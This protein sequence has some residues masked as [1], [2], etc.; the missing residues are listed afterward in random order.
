[1]SDIPGDSALVQCFRAARSAGRPQD[2]AEALPY[3]RFLG[4]ETSLVDGRLQVVLPFRPMLVGNPFLPAIHGGVLG[5]LIELAAS[6]ELI[7]RHDT[8]RL[9]KVVTTTVDFARSGQPR[10]LF[11]EA[12]VTRL[13]RRIATVAVRLWQDDAQR[14][15][16]TGQAHFLLS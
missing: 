16:A 9:P 1:M 10:A 15:I 14:A 8:E 7:W 2:L 5:G 3:A 11:A 12:T 4:V 6:L 13:G